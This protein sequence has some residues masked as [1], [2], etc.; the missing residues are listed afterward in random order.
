MFDYSPVSVGPVPVG[1][2][3]LVHHLP[4]GRYLALVLDAIEPV[5]PRSAGAGPYGYADVTWYL[6]EDGAVDFSAAF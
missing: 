4:T 3:V 6:G 2:I 5:D 1:A